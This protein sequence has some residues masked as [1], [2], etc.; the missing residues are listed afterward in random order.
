MIKRASLI[1]AVCAMGVVFAADAGANPA[2]SMASARQQ[3]Q[4]YGETHVVAANER[5]GTTAT[6]KIDS[7]WRMSSWRVN[8]HVIMDPHKAASDGS[9]V[10]VVCTGTWTTYNDHRGV[11]VKNVTSACS[12]PR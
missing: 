12:M 10:R 9:D 2:L 8:C 5:H 4:R 11:H 3:I 1:L 6:W 7:C